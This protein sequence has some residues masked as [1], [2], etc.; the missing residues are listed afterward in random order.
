MP[1]DTGL[2]STITCFSGRCQPRGRTN[3]T[4]VLSLRLVRLAFGRREVDAAADRVAQVD[5][6]LD[7]VV[8]ARRVRVL[9]VR[10]EHARAAIERVDDHL[11]VDRTRD[12]DAAVLDVGR[13]RRAGP[14][15]FAD[16]ARLGQEVGQLA[17][18]ELG[19]PRGAPREELVAPSAERALQLGHER[20]RLGRQDL[21]VLGRDAAGDFHTGT[22]YVCSWTSRSE[23]RERAGECESRC[24]TDCSGCDALRPSIGERGLRMRN[25]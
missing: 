25:C 14:V 10:H 20:H 24:T 4:A 19:L 18:V 11:A 22:E 7:V 21:R 17:G 9:E 3:S 16:R 5:V 2:P 15:A 8:P 6:A 12:L 13:D 23:S 1:P